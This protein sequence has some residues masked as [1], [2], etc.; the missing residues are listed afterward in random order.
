M[1]SDARNACVRSWLRPGSR[2]SRAARRS[3]K[4]KADFC[5]LRQPSLAGPRGL[6]GGTRLQRLGRRPSNARPPIAPCC[7][8]ATAAVTRGAACDTP[9]HEG[10]GTRP[11][12]ELRADACGQERLGRSSSTSPAPSAASYDEHHR[13]NRPWR[14]GRAGHGRPDSGSS[15]SWSTGQRVEPVMVDRTAGRAGHGRPDSGSSSWTAGRCPGQRVEQPVHGLAFRI[16]SGAPLIEAG[17]CQGMT[18]DVGRGL[19]RV[20]AE[21]FRQTGDLRFEC[22][23]SM[24]FATSPKDASSQLSVIGTPLL[25]SYDVFCFDTCVFTSSRSIG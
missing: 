1:G 23:F 11:C 14:A 15:R 3:G 22:R 21:L 5:L 7:P 18:V 25:P 20:L 24:P 4:T 19:V 9:R 13:R 2:S 16:G 17:P 12:H 10:C 6:R 8:C